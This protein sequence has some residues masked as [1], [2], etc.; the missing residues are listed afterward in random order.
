MLAHDVGELVGEDEVVELGDEEVVV[1]EPVPRNQHPSTCLNLTIIH[2]NINRRRGNICDEIK[3]WKEIRGEVDTNCESD[4][5]R[6]TQE[7]N[8]VAAQMPTN[9]GHGNKQHC[10]QQPLSVKHTPPL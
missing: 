7:E 6:A 10:R 5:E 8:I 1:V 4:E 9:H 2:N 3:D